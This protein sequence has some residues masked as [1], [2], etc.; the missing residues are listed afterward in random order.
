MFQCNTVMN[1]LSN[2]LRMLLLIGLSASCTATPVE[3]TPSVSLAQPQPTIETRLLAFE[4]KV[5]SVTNDAAG[6]QQEGDFVLTLIRHPQFSVTMGDLVVQFGSAVRQSIAERICSF[7]T[8]N[9]HIASA[10][11]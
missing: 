8:S 11:C 1:W 7:R 2:I 10:R 6:M 4:C 5:F 9:D 3:A